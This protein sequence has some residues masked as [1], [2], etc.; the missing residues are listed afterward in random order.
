MSN[1]IVSLPERRADTQNPGN[2]LLLRILCEDVKLRS[3]TVT[4]FSRLSGI[5]RRT[6][7]I[8]TTLLVCYLIVGS[9]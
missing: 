4:R 7:L 3:P 1:R 6:Q 9:L 2:H 8:T 5:H